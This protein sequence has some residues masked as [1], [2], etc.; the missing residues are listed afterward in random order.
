MF[1]FLFS[2]YFLW[3]PSYWYLHLFDIPYVVSNLLPFCW[4]NSTQ[5]YFVLFPALMPESPSLQGPGA[6][7]SEWYSGTPIK[8]LSVHVATV[9]LLGFS[10]DSA[11]V[12]WW[13]ISSWSWYK[14]YFFSVCH[15]HFI[16]HKVVFSYD[17]QY[18]KYKF[19]NYNQIYHIL[20]ITSGFCHN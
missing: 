6:F 4:H 20:C 14:L 18:Y 5:H 10:V 7:S 17:S 19:W 3:S 8:A 13:C 1:I 9:C 11:F 16:S 2:I 15:F 12:G